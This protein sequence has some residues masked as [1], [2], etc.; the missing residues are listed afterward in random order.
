M[1]KTDHIENLRIH[2][3]GTQGSGSVFPDRKERLSQRQLM[4]YKLLKSVFED[5][6][7]H[8]DPETEKLQCSVEE[9]LGG[10]ISRPTL[11]AYRKR[12]VLPEVRSYGGWTTCV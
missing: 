7:N 11:E 6:K 1:N 8:A 2:F 4:E 5:L 12:F 9:I 10:P 3:Y